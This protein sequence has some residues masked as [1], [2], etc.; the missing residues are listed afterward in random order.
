MFFL[1]EYGIAL[2]FYYIGGYV[3][4]TNGMIGTYKVL[5]S[6]E[7]TAKTMKSGSLDV[8]ATPSLVAI[9]EAAAV[10]AIKNELSDAETSVGCFI[11]TSHLA[12]SIIGNEIVA[13]AEVTEANGRQIKFKIMAFDGETIIGEGE[14]SRV[15]VDKEKFMSKAMKRRNDD[16]K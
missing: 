11:S 7:N 4:I 15:I 10:E 16:A 14:H 6:D 3:M 12:P 5:V 13:K 1:S 8:F 9:M 2:F